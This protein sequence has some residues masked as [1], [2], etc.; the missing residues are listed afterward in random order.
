[1]TDTVGARPGDTA[2]LYHRLSS[3][4]FWPGEGVPPPIADERVLQ[5]FVTMDRSRRPPHW[6]VY[7]PSLPTIDL[8]RD[9][10]R[11]A[12]SMTD[13]L[14]GRLPPANRPLDLVGL[15]RLLH[16]SAGVVRVRAAMA[17]Y[18]FMW[19]F[20]AAGSAGGRF[21]LELYV[22]ALGVDGLEDGVWWYEPE[23]HALVRV[24]PAPRGEATALIVTGA[25][26]RTGWRYAERGFRHVYW[27]AGS[28]LAQVLVVAESGDV[29]PRLW[30]RFPD[31]D[32]AATVGADGVE[33]WPVAVVALAPGA[34]AV[35]PG[36]EANVGSIADDQTEFP[37][38][39]LV[40]HTGDMDALGDPW[41]TS[42]PLEGPVPMSDDVDT[43]VLRRG[44]ARTLD[45]AGVVAADACR[46][47]MRAALRGIDTPHVVAVHAVDGIEPGLYR[48]TDLDTPVRTGNLR[49]ELLSIC[50][51][52]D[53]AKDAAFDVIGA[54]D[55]AAI[56]DRGY[57]E[58]QLASGIVEGRL[59]LAAY[60]MGLGA[61]GM[62]FLD[63]ELER[64]LAPVVRGRSIGG[65]LITC[66]GVT[67]YANR[68]GGMPGSP[69]VIHRME[70]RNSPR[71]A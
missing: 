47:S 7:P 51:D 59:H 2:R 34:P 64:L 39:T 19:P 23:R 70:E 60:A 38:V 67:E 24:G 53:L 36:G 46:F 10:V 13:A 65:L 15:S 41:S 4:T 56:D 58:A 9:W 18:T 42:P 30:T 12:V 22:A 68:P 50:W 20:R 11:P 69:A 33:E 48:A 45:P 16:L 43:V 32:V 29:T 21:P 25:P 62:T 71:P 14:A 8:A 44:S 52:M 26:W 35:R 66:V 54:V 63:D 57:R 49:N 40:Q 55:L 28:M 3:Y 37:L 31:A 1:M 27:D 61:S 6:K 5:D 17:P